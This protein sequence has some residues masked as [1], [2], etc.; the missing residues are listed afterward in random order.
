MNESND[1]PPITPELLRKMADEMDATQANRQ[2]ERLRMVLNALAKCSKT[3]VDDTENL[4][5]V[6]ILEFS[7]NTIKVGCTGAFSRRAR[8]I[9][10]GSGLKVV[11]WCH[12]KYIPSSR[13]YAIE[14]LCHKAF[15][16]RRIQGEFFSV[17]FDEARAELA[18]HE[19][20]TEEMNF[21]EYTSC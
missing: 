7:N 8:Q 17:P 16:N 18:K 20:I 4:K 13:A 3:N 1:F 6:Y 19:E 14:N 10:M 2:E 15:E 9:A 5:C 12:T 21:K 11:N